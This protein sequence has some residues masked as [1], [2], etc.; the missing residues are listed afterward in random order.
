[1]DRWKTTDEKLKEM[2]KKYNKLNKRTQD[3]IQ[4]VFDSIDFNVQNL[5]DIASK[6]T[7]DKVNRKI[8][9]YA[10]NNE[11]NEYT[12]YRINKIYRKSR[13]KNNEVLDFLIFMCFLEERNTL[14]KYENNMF[15]E[16][17]NKEYKNAQKEVYTITKEDKKVMPIGNNTYNKIL[18]SPNPKGYVWDE[19]ILATLLFNSEQIYRQ[20]LIELQQNR[21]LDITNDVYQNLLKSQ[22]NRYLSIKDG[23]V[24]SGDLELQTLYM[25][26]SSIKEG[27]IKADNNAKVRFIAEMDKRTTDM[28]ETL[29]DQVFSVNDWNT[30]QRWSAADNKMVVYKTFGLEAGANLP[31]INN[32][33]HWCRSTITYQLEKNISDKVRNGINYIRLSDIE[34]YNNYIDILGTDRVGN[35]DNFIKIKYNKDNT[36]WEFLKREYRRFNTVVSGARNRNR[37]KTLQTKERHANMFYEEVRKRK[38]DSERIS[39]NTKWS[40]EDIEKIR[41]YI[42]IEEH[43]LGD[44]VERFEPDYDMAVSWQRLNDGNNIQEHDLI[45]L[46]HEHYEMELIEKGYSQYEAHIEASKKYNYAKGVDEYNDRG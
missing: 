1:M 44:K 39:K 2:L 14:T 42:F 37:I 6:S 8:E 24:K 27:Y 10:E 9:E 30:Y 23:E 34:Q 32:H 18:S 35:L 3:K 33:F 46:D 26:N 45:L 38:G 43:N 20:A 15:Q 19:Y 21:V 4:E 29:N 16:I 13:I 36:E 7:L 40:V 28:C 11:I 17:I 12:K 31:P 25:A 41:N 22:R 5:F